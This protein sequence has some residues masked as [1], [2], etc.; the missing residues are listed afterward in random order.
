MI[1]D[2]LFVFISGALFDYTE[3]FNLVFYLGGIAIVIGG[4]LVCTL[5][6]LQLPCYRGKQ[7]VVR[8]GGGG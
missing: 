6:F 8:R 1:V 2:S 7:G 5:N 4:L 3:D